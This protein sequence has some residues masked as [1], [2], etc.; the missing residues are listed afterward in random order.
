[1]A[2]IVLTTTCLVALLFFLVCG[3]G[4]LSVGSVLPVLVD[5]VACLG[6][7]TTDPWTALLAFAG[8]LKGTCFLGTTFLGVDF[9]FAL[10]SRVNR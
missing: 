2:K 4:A 8:T 9:V 7:S 3:V 6:F 5:P 1:M 10:K